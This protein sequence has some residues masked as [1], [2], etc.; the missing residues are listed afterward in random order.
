MRHFTSGNI[1]PH[2]KKHG[3]TAILANKMPFTSG[4]SA[5]CLFLL[6]LA[7]FCT[8]PLYAST[9]DTLA[10]KD[11][12][13][14]LSS[15]YFHSPAL[16][17]LQLDT[18]SF[19]ELGQLHDGDWV[20]MPD[21]QVF[22]NNDDNHSLIKIKISNEQQIDDEHFLELA[23]NYVESASLY[24]FDTN[25]QSIVKLYPASGNSHLFDSRPIN[26]RHIVYPVPIEAKQSITLLLQV[27]HHYPTRLKL[28]ASSETGFVRKINRELIIFGM[29]YG[30][31]LM[32][33][34]YNLF[35][36]ASLKEKSHL[37][38][39]TFGTLTGI[40]IAIHEGHFSQF[41]APSAD[42]NKGI[43]FSFVSALMCFSFSF[44][45][46][47]FLELEKHSPT[48]HQII[49]ATGSICAVFLIMLGFT[50]DQLI[51]SN[52]SFLII[53]SLYSIAIWAGL[54][55]WYKGVT[56]AGFFS[57]AIFFS[58]LGLFLEYLSQLSITRLLSPSF[59]YATAGYTAMI[60]V[61]AYALADKMRLLQQ[62][63]LDASLKL[64]KLTEE[65]SQSNL[66]IYKTKLL[67]V[68][69][70]KES[71]TAKHQLQ[72]KS[73]FLTYMSHEIRTPMNSLMGISELM[74]DTDLTPKQLTYVNSITHSSSALLN[75][76]NDVLD[77]SQF[78]S[79]QMELESRLFNLEK[80]ADDC[81]N[82]FALS[83]NE[84]NLDLIAYVS[85]S[86]PIELKGDSE[87]IKQVCLNLLNQIS[88][89]KGIEDLSLH[90]Q[91]TGKKT[92][93]SVEIIFEIGFSGEDLDLAFF[94]HWQTSDSSH[95]SNELGLT[96]NVSRQLI[97]LMNGRLSVHHEAIK[98]DREETGKHQVRIDFTARLLLP[99]TGENLNIEDRNTLLK[100]RRILI[101]HSNPKLV[102]VIQ[103]LCISWGMKC[104]HADGPKKSG[105]YLL[106]DKKPYQLLLIE[107]EQLTPELQLSIRQA[108]LE[109]NYLTTVSLIA[110]AQ[111]SMTKDEMKRK[112]IRCLFNLPFTTSQLYQTILTSMGIE[113]SND[114]NEQDEV[115]VLIAEDNAVNLMV[116]EG[117][118]IKQGLSPVSCING[119]EAIRL[120]NKA[121]GFDL[122]FMDCE[123][124]E[125]NGFDATIAIR[126]QESQQEQATPATIIGLSAH[127]TSQSRM[128][129]KEAGMDDFLTKPIKPEDIEQIV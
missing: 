69:S 113:A 65:K 110:P 59:S 94:E 119:E 115:S 13:P 4:I 66:A 71:Q 12:Q 47:Y 101:C 90:I 116:I 3:S 32:I 114:I 33:V 19:A 118:L 58:S 82:I 56:S 77:F 54:K 84:N 7:S 99:H 5:T 36:Y 87:K 96:L 57:L 98:V 62:E 9:A 67:E 1:L 50:E 29:I 25:R 48:I 95:D 97:E 27:T 109:H 42:W 76:I 93:N 92:V 60:F 39:Y 102:N 104:V 38:F 108:N 26:Y 6:F 34:M 75:V 88:Q 63:R 78:E 83:S 61:F 120:A 28:T 2:K 31:L 64:V 121:A 117:L 15:E 43:I 37:L 107:K 22:L 91:P 125:A 72:A 53:F 55:I 123:M 44:F 80:V 52:I 86:T 35:I 21:N 10:L 45:S 122:I 100:D 127:T 51:F 20:N 17:N 73:E 70:E 24:Y 85:P 16:K 30:S 8:T 128:Q 46:S 81:V 79:D 103:E 124:P 49:L 11:N 126:N 112:G 111:F 41:V 23:S 14:Q 89:K 68:Q 18:L 105:E 129:A 106:H 74:K 40:F